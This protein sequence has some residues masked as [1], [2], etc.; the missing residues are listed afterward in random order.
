MEEEKRRRRRKEK[1]RE[2]KILRMHRGVRGEG[3]RHP[4]LV[5]GRGRRLHGKG[6]AWSRHR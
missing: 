2:G 3:Y 5:L 6:V 1:E 4:P